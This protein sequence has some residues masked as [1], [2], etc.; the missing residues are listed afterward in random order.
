MRYMLIFLC[1]IGWSQSTTPLLRGCTDC[2]AHVD[3]YGAQYYLEGKTLYKVTDRN[4]MQHA[5]LEYGMPAQLIT[6]N[7]L[8]LA[9]Y[10][11]QAQRLVYLD[12]RLVTIREIDMN[13][14][15]NG[16]SYPYAGIAA[17]QQIWLYNETQNRLEVYDWR[18]ERVT[19]VSAP[20][21]ETILG[22]S[23][24]YNTCRLL[25]KDQVLRFNV[26]GT[27]LPATPLPEDSGTYQLVPGSELILSSGNNVLRLM[28]DAWQSTLHYGR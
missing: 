3:E 22:I 21:Q 14:I 11:D 13:R 17:Q 8:Q 15:G 18:L 2:L 12:N 10:Y 4:V 1:F 23:S 27:Q 19:F 25:T 20:L 9:L 26:Y 5:S 16:D 24:N 7:P 6:T 28:N